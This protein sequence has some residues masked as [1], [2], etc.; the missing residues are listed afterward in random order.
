MTET[1]AIEVVAWAMEIRVLV[2]GTGRGVSEE[3]GGEESTHIGVGESVL[4]EGG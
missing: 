3:I 1:T 2:E 4:Q